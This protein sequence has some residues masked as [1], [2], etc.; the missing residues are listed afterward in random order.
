[1]INSQVCAVGSFAMT[2]GVVAVALFTLNAGAAAAA[3]LAATTSPST[4]SFAD[5]VA[6][7]GKLVEPVIAAYD[8]K[9]ES[10]TDPWSRELTQFAHYALG[11]GRDPARAEYALRKCFGAQ[12]TDPKSP[13]Y[14]TVLWKQNHPEIKDPN[15][16]E[17]TLHGMAPAL[18][19]HGDR[20]S[21]AMR[22]Y[23]KPHLIAARA[24]LRAHRVQP[25]YTNIYLMKAT[26]LLLVGQYLADDTAVSEARQMLE[27]WV[28]GVR[29]H[30]I[31][32]YDCPVYTAIVLNCLTPAHDLA[33][34]PR[35]RAVLK[36]ALDYVWADSLANYFPGQQTLAGAQSRNYSFTSSVGGLCNNYFLAGVRPTP[37]PLGL[38]N[39]GPDTYINALE[40]G[41]N[42]Y[43]P[44]Q[45]MLSL[46][47]LPT[48][49]IHQRVGPDQG[50]DRTTYITKDF[51][52]GTASHWYGEQDRLVNVQFAS[53]KQLPDIVVIAD[54]F[55]SPYGRVKRPDR[56]GHQK[57]V[58]LKRAVSITQQEGTVL[59]LFDVVGAHDHAMTSVATN[60][61]LPVAADAIY[62][63]DK[64]IPTTQTF[65]LPVALGDV[66]L[67]REGRAA[68][69]VRVL[70]ADAVAGN[71]APIFLKWDGN[72]AQAA[73]L[74][75]YHYAG[76]SRQLPRAPVRMAVLIAAE[77]C[78]SD[79]DARRL[80]DSIRSTTVVDEFN[81]GR[82]SITANVSRPD[83]R[84]LQL[85]AALDMTTG[86]AVMRRVNGD[87]VPSEVFSINGRDLVATSFRS[88]RGN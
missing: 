28:A 8:A 39:E 29:E 22:D 34:D 81:Q 13:S 31:T 48:R 16:I 30:G 24:A 82:W 11:T 32:E 57:P 6:E 78:E 83:A 14:G 52:I 75:A 59:A 36:Q 43:Q 18:I 38:F 7:F 88:S 68:V 26:N 72:D 54:E 40:A 76:E 86:G 71:E 12:D 79:A 21:P 27:T 56:A 4:T 5:R 10:E 66:V 60:V 23:L 33:A 25:P 73:R 50:I 64:R 53:A 9:L 51:A 84:A 67:I 77:S 35:D 74:V 15:A 87:E 69:A 2:A 62:V 80:V 17:F 19:R 85:S 63:N 70:H 45:E 49:L 47:R 41:S 58:Q 46:A 44:D 37:G 55:D 65:E 1:V 20:L 61:L 42:G 3:E